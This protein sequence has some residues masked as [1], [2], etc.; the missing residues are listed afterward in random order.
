MRSQTGRRTMHDRYDAELWNAHHDQ[1]S[2]WIERLARAGR[3]ILAGRL[4]ALEP[5]AG[6]LLAVTGAL[7]LTL[8]TFT[9][10]AA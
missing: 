1:F 3:R 6:Q 10:S 9:A 2:E 7:G 5:A 4:S 8:L